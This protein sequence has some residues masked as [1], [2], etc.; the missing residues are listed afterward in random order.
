V[1]WGDADVPAH[2]VRVSPYLDDPYREAFAVESRTEYTFVVSQAVPGMIVQL[3]ATVPGT[4]P[5]REQTLTLEPP[6]TAS[7]KR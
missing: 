2:T 7:D 1:R 5:L 4:Q 6:D 3:R